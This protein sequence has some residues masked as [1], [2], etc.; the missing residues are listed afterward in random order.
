MSEGFPLYHA[1][2][3]HAW[4]HRTSPE[5][6]DCARQGAIGVLPVYTF[7][8]HEPDW[9]LDTEEWI[10]GQVLK[11]SLTI[12][13][14]HDGS[15]CS[16]FLVLPPLRHCPA[17]EVGQCF[18]V[19][20]NTGGRLLEDLLRSVSHSGFNRVIVIHVNPQI[21]DWLDCVLRDVRLSTGLDLYR[22][23]LDGMGLDVRD[24]SVRSRLDSCCRDG[25][26]NPLIETAGTRLH[27]L[28]RQI[29]RHRFPKLGG[30]E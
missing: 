30:S 8:R 22:I 16:T 14:A 13:D 20:L 12:T 23:G 3:Q 9:P 11:E 17:Q 26:L 5:L 19:D 28:L 1:E 15:F 10:G 29:E 6:A 24:A 21:A 27:S 18:T 25:D 2:T 7:S 4:H